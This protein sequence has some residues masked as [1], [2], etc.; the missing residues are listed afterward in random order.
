MSFAR[1]IHRSHTFQQNCYVLFL[2]TWNSAEQT[3]DIPMIWEAMV[4]SWSHYNKKVYSL[5]PGNGMVDLFGLVAFLLTLRPFIHQL[6][7]KYKFRLSKNVSVFMCYMYLFWECVRLC[8]YCYISWTEEV[9]HSCRAQFVRIRHIKLF[10]CLI[11]QMNSSAST[12]T[13]RKEGNT[14]V[15]LHSME[16]HVISLITFRFSIT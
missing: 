6:L 16:I 5:A 12:K 8:F 9:R 3:I 11:L 2:L 4:L 10:F 15:C 1:G 7:A 13:D 14:C